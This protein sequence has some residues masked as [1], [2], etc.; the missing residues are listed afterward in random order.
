MMAIETSAAKCELDHVGFA[1]NG[2][3]LPAYRRYDRAVPLPRIGWQT[4]AR[5]DKARQALGRLEVF[6]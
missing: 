5:S 4:T 1:D 3:E 2:A 6:D